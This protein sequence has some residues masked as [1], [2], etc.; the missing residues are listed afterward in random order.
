MEG[1]T[2]FRQV[3]ATCHLFTCINMMYN[4]PLQAALVGVWNRMGVDPARLCGERSA[5]QEFMDSL[6]GGWG[7]TIDMGGFEGD[8]M[9]MLLRRAAEE[10]KLQY[11]AAA[12]IDTC[13]AVRARAD[14]PARAAPPAR[15]SALLYMLQ[16][17]ATSES[18]IPASVLSS[19]ALEMFSLFQRGD[20]A[21]HPGH[22]TL[23]ISDRNPGPCEV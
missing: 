4:S 6:H 21:Q 16:D 15:S 18:T 7:A 11:E 2:H 9:F 10:G 8:S 19:Q 1:A 5:V 14:P 20:D 13:Y 17:P 23:G 22:I 3:G 12:R